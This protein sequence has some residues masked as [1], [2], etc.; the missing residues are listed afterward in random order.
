ML[1][2]ARESLDII[3][4]GYQEGELDYLAVLSVQQ[5]YAEKN[6][7]YLQDLETAWKRWAEIDGL[8]VGHAVGIEMERK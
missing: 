3:N 6:L 5:T 2:V 4:T 7:S 1:P 8:L